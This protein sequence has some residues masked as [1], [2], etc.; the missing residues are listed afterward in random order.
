METDVERESENRDGGKEDRR[1]E[2]KRAE[3]KRK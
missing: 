1:I 2:S 3:T